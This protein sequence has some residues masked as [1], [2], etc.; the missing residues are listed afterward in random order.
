MTKYYYSPQLNDIFKY[1]G[2]DI[3]EWK[4]HK[5]T[6][7]RTEIT[8]RMSNSDFEEY[9]GSFGENSISEKDVGIHFLGIMDEDSV[10]D[11]CSS[12]AKYLAKLVDNE[13][14]STASREALR[15]PSYKNKI[16]E[17]LYEKLW[18]KYWTPEHKAKVVAE[19]E[20]QRKVL[21]DD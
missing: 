6:S 10:L 1:Q 17:G 16:P 5:L 19:Q 14:W 11:E 20:R 8:F 18:R 4:R 21:N 3:Y 13:D 2:Y 7:M 9:C 15:S 12:H